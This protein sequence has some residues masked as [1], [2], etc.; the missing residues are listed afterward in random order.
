MN[1]LNVDNLVVE[2]LNKVKIDDNI[3]IENDVHE[4]ALVFRFAHYLANIIENTVSYKVDVEYNRD[5]CDVKR[6]DNQ[7]RRVDLIVHKRATND[8]LFAIEFKKGHESKTDKIELEKL[9]IEYYY[10]SV[11][12]IDFKSGKIETYKNNEWVYIQGDYHE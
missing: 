3:L 8:N 2:M 7:K 4:I 9:K 5:K 6:I 10:K 1:K 11:Y 12:Y